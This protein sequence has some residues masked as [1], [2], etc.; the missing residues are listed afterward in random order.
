MKPKL[1][2]LGYT[3]GVEKTVRPAAVPGNYKDPAKIAEKQKEL[4]AEARANSAGIPTAGTL[5]DYVILERKGRIVDRGDPD[6]HESLAVQLIRALSRN[7]P[8][9]GRADH[10]VNADGLCVMGFGAQACLRVA[11]LEAIRDGYQIGT[12]DGCVGVPVDLY[13]GESCVYDPYLILLHSDARRHVSL[14]DLF[15]YLGIPYDPATLAD[16]HTQ[17]SLAKAVNDRAQ[18][19]L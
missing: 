14:T 17:A 18:L 7:F 15:D 12:D 4:E 1:F 11:C 2:Y 19:I 10:P 8:G 6:G 3:L 16:P 5:K 9:F 13:R